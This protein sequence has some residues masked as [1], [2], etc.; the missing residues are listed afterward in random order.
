MFEI[1]NSATEEQLRAVYHAFGFCRDHGLDAHVLGRWLQDAG[2]R[3]FADSQTSERQK[4]LF[5]TQFSLDLTDRF[6]RSIYFDSGQEYKEVELWRRLVSKSAQVWDVGANFGLYTVSSA[7]RL[8]KNGKVYAFEPNTAC[9][10]RL[11]KNVQSNGFAQRCEL[12]QVAL[13]SQARERTFYETNESAFSGLSDTGRVEITAQTTVHTRPLDDVWREVGARPIDLLKIDV[14][15]HEDEV[16]AGAEQ[17]L[18]ASPDLI[19]QFEYSEKNLSAERKAGLTSI[20]NGLVVQGFR[21][22]QLWPV[23]AEVT[24]EE[25]EATIAD[26]NCYLVASNKAEKKLRKAAQKGSKVSPPNAQEIL[27]TLQIL[28]QF[29]QAKDKVH[30][31]AMTNL[32]QSIE[33]QAETIEHLK[34]LTQKKQSEKE[35]AV[36]A[37]AVKR[38]NFEQA[39]NKRIQADAQKIENLGNAMTDLRG[40]LAE[41]GE[42]FK[43]RLAQQ[44]EGFKGRIAEQNEAFKQRSFD[45]SARMTQQADAF[46]QRII[47]EKD[48]RKASAQKAE[49]ERKRGNAF[50]N[51]SNRLLDE[52]RRERN[53]VRLLQT[54]LRR[55][56]RKT[57]K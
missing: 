4:E 53:R 25:M 9:F 7:A 46:K 38:S 1:D 30:R 20:I 21:I 8:R 42:V 41:Q 28:D 16:L 13:D 24:I 32:T 31:D 51:L 11:Q 12:F 34:L 17:A 44:G 49:Q 55:T 52:L 23:L 56:K 54:T 48:L 36:K 14:E 26:G 15:G 2:R 45:Q 47:E 18:A 57:K 50:K 10:D 39:Y 3:S 5:G 33:G 19:V 27:T 22:L 40:R 29:A 6:A 35:V 37:A 43:Q